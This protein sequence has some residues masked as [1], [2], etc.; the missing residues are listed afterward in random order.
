MVARDASVWRSTMTE[1]AGWLEQLGLGKYAERFAENEIDLA[2]LPH[3]SDADLQEIGLPLGPRRKIQQALRD[4]AA[5]Q[6]EVAEP[7]GADRE[8]RTEQDQETRGERRPVTVLFADLCGFTKLSS[9]LDA[10]ATHAL[11]NRYFAVVDGIVERYGGSIDKHIGDSV[12]AVFGAPIAHSNDPERAVRAACDI[13][14]AMGAL[15]AEAG[16]GLQA[17]IGIASGQ[18]I[19]SGTGSDAYREYTVTGDTV[20]LASRLD[21]MA[22][23][24]ET[25]ISAA[26]QDAVARLAISSERGEAAVKGLERPLAVWALEAVRSEAAPLRLAAFVARELELEQFAPSCRAASKPVAGRAWSCAGRSRYRQ[27]PLG[28]GVREDG[29]RARLHHP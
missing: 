7:P 24:G 12:M 27:D 3:L 2:I 15:S 5:D 26:V 20:N 9:E 14:Q 25:L 17:H 4:G 28:R 10:E 1:I 16:K 18:V 8:H 21:D 13:H 11:L 29:R 6:G 19:A 22:G 23:P